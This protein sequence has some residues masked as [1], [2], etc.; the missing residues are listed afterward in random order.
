MSQKQNAETDD[1]FTTR[2]HLYLITEHEDEDRVGLVKLADRRLS[3]PLKNHEG[4][5][6]TYDESEGGFSTIGKQVGMGYADFDSPEDLEDRV[7]AI[8]ERKL[9]DLDASH[10]RKAGHTDKIEADD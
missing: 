5:I 6:K 7:P 10:L 2:K 4:P 9:A 3:I 1:G 8:A